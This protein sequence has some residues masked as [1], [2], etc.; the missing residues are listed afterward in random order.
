MFSSAKVSFEQ[1]TSRA[2]PKSMRVRFYPFGGY[3]R[4]QGWSQRIDATLHR[5]EKWM[6]RKQKKRRRGYTAAE[7]AEVFDRW[8]RGESS[9]GIARALN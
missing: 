7:L 9:V 4:E 3:C 5:E 8:Q 2:G 6:Q 1:S